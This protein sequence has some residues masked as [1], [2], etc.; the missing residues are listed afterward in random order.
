[1]LEHNHITRGEIAGCPSCDVRE[2]RVPDP[3]RIPAEPERPT[4]P[5]FVKAMPEATHRLIGGRFVCDGDEA[6][7]CRW[8]PD[9]CGCEYWPCGH[10]YTAHDRC[11]MADWFDGFDLIDTDID[12]GEHRDPET[13][14]YPDGEIECEW[15]GE[16]V[17]WRYVSEP[18][19]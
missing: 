5:D 16:A 10:D 2:G 4:V 13:L 17:L 9:D 3:M 15:G 6:N 7:R 14:V 1:M 8:Y 11:W 12:E 18:T 19:D